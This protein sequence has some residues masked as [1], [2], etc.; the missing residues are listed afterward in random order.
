[1]QRL[2][3]LLNGGEDTVALLE[4]TPVEWRQRAA[5][6]VGRATEDARMLCLFD[7]DLK[8]AGLGPDG[9]IRL[10]TAAIQTYSKHTEGMVYFGLLSHTFSKGQVEARWRDL[11]RDDPS[12]LSRC[13]PIAKESLDDPLEFAHS[14]KLAVINLS[15]ERL[16][17]AV[18][19]ISQDA[20]D[21]ALKG[22]RDLTVWDF[23]QIV[24]QSSE[25]EGVWE[26]ETLFRVYGIFERTARR[27]RALAEHPTFDALSGLIRSVRL[28]ETQ[29]VTPVSQQVRTLRRAELYEGSEINRFLLPTELGDLFVRGNQHYVLVAQPCDLMVRGDGTRWLVA[30]T[31]V[32]VRSYEEKRTTL[33]IYPECPYFTELEDGRF[34]HFDFHSVVDVSLD[35]LDLAA[36]RP[37][38]ECQF[39][40]AD[41][42]PADAF[43]PW[44]VRYQALSERFVVLEVPIK[45]TLDA[46]GA[47]KASG[48]ERRQVVSQL[49]EGF[50]LTPKFLSP[51]YQNGAFSFGLKRVGRYLNP[52]AG[53][54][55]A[56][57]EAFR[58][59]AALEHDFARWGNAD[60]K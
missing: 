9:G 16:K 4:L 19:R 53:V 44:K 20:R 42:P 29:P 40:P 58:A 35:V 13:L 36:L 1:M 57:Y 46:L 37:D 30:G 5:E 3:D 25:Y 39:R 52:A 12:L 47:A 56:R 51:T 15:H 31:L 38:G 6:I 32:P 22:L 26:V 34:W 14:V 23:D 48:N 2:A 54:L 8:L 17:E 33:D 11:G 7:Q 28:V 50:C 55:L 41:P 59:R 43:A 18:Q 49:L 10:L 45:R 24:L 21:E 27:Q 60:R